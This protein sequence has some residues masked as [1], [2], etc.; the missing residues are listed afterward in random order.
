MD[1]VN[2]ITSLLCFGGGWYL[3]HINGWNAMVDEWNAYMESQEEEE[4]NEV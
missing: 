3:G 2:I 1:L 4:N